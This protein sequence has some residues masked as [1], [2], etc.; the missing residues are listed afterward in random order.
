MNLT[1]RDF[2]FLGAHLQKIEIK[3]TNNQLTR[4]KK[5]KTSRWQ[6]KMFK[7]GEYMLYR[8]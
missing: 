6:Q 2:E 4:Q 5:L 8:P 1:R 7:L 3:L